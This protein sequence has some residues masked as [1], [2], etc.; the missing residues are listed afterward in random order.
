MA[1]Y[2][3]LAVTPS[4]ED[5]IPAYLPAANKLVA[6]HGGKYLART[7]SHEQVEGGE[8]TSALRIILEWPSKETAMSFMNDPEYKPHL[9]ART[10]GSESYH[11]VIEG[12]DDLA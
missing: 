7:A 11:F 9:D 6:K 4:R 12:K 1:Y 10:A 3:V 8:Q 5:W 2:S